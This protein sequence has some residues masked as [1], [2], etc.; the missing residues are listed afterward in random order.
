MDSQSVDWKY[1]CNTTRARIYLLWAILVFVGFVATHFY[2]DHNINY[3]W[4]GLSVVGL[5]YMAR[6]MPMAVKQMRYI[7]LAWL[8]PI[9]AGIVVTGSV[10]YIHTSAAAQLLGHL[11]AFWLFVMAAGYIL[12]GLADRPS[13]WYWA[14]AS[15]HI[16]AGLA[17]LTVD[18]LL[19]GQYLIAAIIGAWSMLNLWIFR[20]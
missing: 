5:G 18:E 17:C 3:V 2:Q 12:N 9:V 19:P 6:H 15:M 1:L 16:V 14:A 20:S 7:L 13:Y 11:G 8:V 4:T 10:F